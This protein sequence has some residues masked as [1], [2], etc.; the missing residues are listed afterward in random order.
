M[1]AGARAGK[2]IA[3]PAQ[4]S[5]TPQFLVAIGELRLPDKDL[6]IVCLD[7]GS[8][9]RAFKAFMPLSAL[10]N[11]MSSSDTPL[12]NTPEIIYVKERNIACDG[13]GGA[14]GHPKVWYCLED[15]VAVCRYCERK[16][17]YDRT[18]TKA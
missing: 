7:E 4:T 18:L 17:V 8:D 12:M 2:A 16:F 15:G 5:F 3:S 10:S 11:A 13:G 1:L 14:L 9:L 6:P